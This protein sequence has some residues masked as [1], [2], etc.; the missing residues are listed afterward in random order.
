M[1]SFSE[2]KSDLML[3]LMAVFKSE[4]K[5]EVF[6]S[7]LDLL[8]EEVPF[9]LHKLIVDTEL[10][11]VTDPF[12]F[13]LVSLLMRDYNHVDED[14]SPEQTITHSVTSTVPINDDLVMFQSLQSPEAFLFISPAKARHYR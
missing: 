3:R 12:S 10:S 8:S 5:A 7:E 1:S 4:E 6:R 13:R 9:S 14:D 11:P 2:K